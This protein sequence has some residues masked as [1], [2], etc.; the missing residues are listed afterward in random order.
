MTEKRPFHHALKV[1][2]SECK[3]CTRC[4][5]ICPTEAIRVTRGKAHVNP[6]RCI[7]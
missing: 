2:I 1:L 4:M 5:R 3:G 7:D 6:E